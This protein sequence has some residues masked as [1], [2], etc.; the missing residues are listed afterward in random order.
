MVWLETAV[1]P[2]GGI[3][4]I[5]LVFNDFHFSKFATRRSR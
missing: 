2:V 3:T 5:Q 4:K 1:T